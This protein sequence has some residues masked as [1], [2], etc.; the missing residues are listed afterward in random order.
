MSSPP[1]PVP[2]RFNRL[3]VL[4]AVGLLLSA[5]GGLRYYAHVAHGQSELL[6]NQRAVA[7]SML[8]A[9]Q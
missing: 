7:C 4:V 3:I 1:R 8:A 6:L 2:H 9:T 5:C